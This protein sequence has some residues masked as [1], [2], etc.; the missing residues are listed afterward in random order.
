MSWPVIFFAELLYWNEV[1]C[2]VDPV[3][4]EGSIWMIKSV[5][6]VNGTPVK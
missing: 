6:Q 2:R 4:Q 3:E 1:T 5:L